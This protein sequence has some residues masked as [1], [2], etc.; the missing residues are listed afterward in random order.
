MDKII[1]ARKYVQKNKNKV[2]PEYRL[3]YHVMGEVGWINDPNGFCYYNGE[4]HLFFQYHPFSSKWGPM[5]WGHVKSKDLI[6]WEYLPIALAPD[7]DYDSEG[8][9]S[10]SAIEKDGKLYL[11]YTGHVNPDSSND[12]SV[13]QTQCIA[14]SEDG[15]NFN[16]AAQNPVIGTKDLPDNALPQDFR[17]PKV[18]KRD[19]W[20]F[21]IVGSRNKDTSG[22][23]LLYKSKD[24]FNWSYVG[25]MAGSHNEVGKMWECPDFFY[26]DGY[27]V[28]IVSP[29]DI[30]RDGDRYN[31]I[32]ASVYMLGKMDLESGKYTY[33]KIDEIDFGL[34]F[35]APQTLIDARGRRIL[36][37]WMQ[38]WHRRIPTDDKNHN[39]AGAMT[40][41]RELS[42]I[43]G[44]LY[45]KPIEEIKNYRTNPLNYKNI[46]VDKTLSLHGIKGQCIELE[47]EI[48]SQESVVFGLKVLKG[49][50]QE[51]VMYYDKVEER[52]VFNR[53]RSGEDLSAME[54]GTAD[55]RKVPLLL[56]NNILKMHIFI[57]RS[58]VEIF[59][60]DGER[61]MTSTV[62]SDNS[63]EAIEF[64]CDQ[65]I[66]IKNIDKWDIS[67]SFI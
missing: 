34:D 62:Y 60:Q 4:Y 44:K 40:L 6:K 66:V 9:F 37:A 19:G 1:N 18:F 20:Y 57:D 2:N 48:D 67:P 64:F 7:K 33:D 29:Q 10:G 35:Y 42:I 3:G 50:T 14:F 24:L 58:S 32:Y 30:E 12:E 11:M 61:V 47:A 25:I 28:L 22:Q 65:E 63:S 56:K 27:D 17:D 46:K 59:L 26:L 15:I 31:N 45:Q 23:I 21:V 53:S 49:E 38:M 13:R 8:C 39:W 41:P 5:H 55:L 36:I 51:T 16:K 54:I 43:D 52:F